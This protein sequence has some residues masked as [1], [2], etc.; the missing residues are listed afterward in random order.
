MSGEY[1]GTGSKFV[2]VY[3]GITLL[4]ITEQPYE[5]RGGVGKVDVTSSGSTKITYL[6]DLAEDAEVDLTVNGFM[7]SG[8]SAAHYTL[9]TDTTAGTLQ[10]YYEGTA[11]GAPYL[12]HTGATIVNKR[13]GSPFRSGQQYSFTFHTVDGPFTFGTI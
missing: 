7:P 10:V 3:K 1:L 5:E 11:S 4:N 2:V 13:L 12:L 6:A 8:A 9:N